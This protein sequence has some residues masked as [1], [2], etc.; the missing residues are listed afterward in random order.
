MP[1]RSGQPMASIGSEIAR[2]RSRLRARSG[3]MY[4]RRNPLGEELCSNI[5]AIG[6]ITAAK[7]LPDPVGT[8]ISP[9]L[10]SK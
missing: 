7:V 9:L 5:R 8:W 2:A 1:T 4:S 3:V 6:P 10:P